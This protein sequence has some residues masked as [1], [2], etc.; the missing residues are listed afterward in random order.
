M[1]LSRT[2]EQWLAELKS[3]GQARTEAL[4]D[5]RQIVIAGLRRGLLSQINT[6]VPEFD[7]QVEDFAQET[8][9]RLLD[10]LDSF[11]GRSQFTTWVHKIA[12]SIALTELRRK[13]WRDASLSTLTEGQEG[14]SYTPQLVTDP[15]PAPDNAAE[16]A[17]LLL[18]VNQI[19]A[20]TLTPK[21]RAALVLHILQ[22]KTAHEVAQ[23]LNTN[24]NAVYKL[25]HD[26]RVRLKHHLEAEGLTPGD[27]LA[28]FE[29]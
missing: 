26:A 9:L 23:S 6:A 14:D 7:A 16:R 13:R 21:Q 3:T 28:T 11:A 2:N 17:D 18:R 20:Q 24:P 29:S 10:N 19:V 27:I 15:H 25:L 22:G 5:L 1:T 12:V 8:L 4:S